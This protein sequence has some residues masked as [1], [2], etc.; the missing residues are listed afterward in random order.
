MYIKCIASVPEFLERTNLS[1]TNMAPSKKRNVNPRN[2]SERGSKAAKVDL[3]SVVDR[4]LES[5]KHA[6][7]VFDILESLQVSFLNG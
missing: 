3:E 5:R 2:T 7:D 6:N 4:I 1:K